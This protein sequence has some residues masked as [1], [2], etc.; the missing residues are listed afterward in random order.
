MCPAPGSILEPGGTSTD[1]Q[2]QHHDGSRSGRSAGGDVA[3]RVGDARQAGG[4]IA[5]TGLWPVA[6]RSRPRAG[7]RRLGSRR[8]VV[9]SRH[10][11]VRYSRGRDD[12]DRR[13]ASEPL[14]M[15]VVDLARQAGTDAAGE[16]VTRADFDSGTTRLEVALATLRVA[17]EGAW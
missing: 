17:A 9:R 15:A 1:V 2:A 6:S 11:A 3:Q 8:T 16:L 4:E 14:A 7:R 13:R 12:V 5:T 10:V